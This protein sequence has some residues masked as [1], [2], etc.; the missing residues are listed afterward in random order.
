MGNINTLLSLDGESEFRRQL[1]FITQNLKTLDKAL[2]E[3]AA[4]F[5][6]EADKMKL[7]S[8]TSQNL[9]R[10]L[11]LLK[12][13]Q[14]LLNS[15]VSSSFKTVQDQTKKLGEAKQAY[16]NSAIA[17]DQLKTQLKAAEETYGRNSQEAKKLRAELKAA[18]E[19]HRQNAKAVEDAEKKLDRATKVNQQYRQQLS[20]TNTQIHN[21]QNELARLAQQEDTETKSTQRATESTNTFK[22]A[23][24][25][26]KS[27]LEAAGTACAKIAQAEFKTL[28]ATFKAIGTELELGVSGLKKYTEAVAAAGV[29]IGS[30]ATSKGMSFEA[31]MSKVEAYSN[32]SAEELE[33][34]SSAAKEMG[35]TTS[36]TASEAA[37]ALGY[38]ALN[39]YNTEEM[40]SSLK[41]I[42]KASEAGGMSLATVAD[43]VANSLTSYGKGAED[44]E[45]FLNVLTATQN[46]SAT[47]MEQLLTTYRDLSG[48]FKML[49]VDFNES[50]TLLGLVANRGLKG[51]EAGTA[52]NSVMLRL[53]GTN[54]N[55]AT[56]LNSIGVSAWDAEGNFKGLTNTLREVSAK[57]EDMTTEEKTLFEKEVS[58]V[59]RFQEFNKLL[60][61]ANDLENY[62][63]LYNEVSH[64]MENNYLY[65][66]AETMMDNLKGDITI[67]KSATEALGISIFDTF[68]DE[69]VSNVEKMTFWVNKL[70]DG[71]KN[72]NLLTQLDQVAA[73]MSDALVQGINLASRELPSKLKVFNSAILN[74]VKLLIKGISKSKNTILPELITGAKDLVLGLVE[75]LPEFTKEVTDGAVIM[76]TGLV[77]AMFEI[78]GKLRE[79]M[80]EVLN[81][82][83]T[84]IT[85]HGPYIFETG[86][87]VLMNLINGIL[88]NLPQ[89]MKAAQK[90]LNKLISGI[91]KHM[92]EIIKGGLEILTALLRGI[93]DNFGMILQTAFDILDELVK[94]LTKDDTLEKLIDAAIDIVNSLLKFM[95]DNLPTVLE[96]WI[97]DIMDSIAKAFMDKEE[98]KKLDEAGNYLGGILAKAIK[99]GIVA[100]FKSGEK[101]GMRALLNMLGFEGDTADMVMNVMDI[102]NKHQGEVANDAF[103]IEQ[104]ITPQPSASTQATS[105][106][107]PKKNE[108]TSDNVGLFADGSYGPVIN[109]YS[110]V[111][112]NKADAE[113]V[114]EQAAQ[115]QTV[116]NSSGG[117]Y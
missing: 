116:A 44:A 76:F 103:M 37:D 43:A 39:G 111:I 73:G 29:A 105:S 97:P 67:L 55:A 92:P 50:A 101:I 26:L 64:A 30:F 31:S 17:V 22:T 86:F 41:P 11:D 112:N 65:S 100:I 81:T 23:L 24:S 49:D 8:Q 71:V 13:K 98:E 104:G 95:F 51:A 107:S 60:D 57:M 69:A 45:E 47:S 93:A 16:A 115:L 35:A 33:K 32:A 27:A 102:V 108:V 5:A 2:T 56:A 19:A 70:N 25:G 106:S 117:R 80:P 3:T 34:L 82:L 99:S 94:D 61:A 88:E 68:S 85:E 110:P 89:I 1:N 72:G 52:L 91:N 79:K 75:Q 74:G 46:N 28:E 7:T 10:Q 48:T 77:D 83:L 12:N 20:E 78:S 21:T 15:A 96:E 9:E 42:V 114:A 62:E 109:F 63:E 113:R 38:L 36:K 53:L 40:L 18:E 59:M 90:I 87:E 58:G 54:K 14:T 66:T 84:A 4:M 6:N